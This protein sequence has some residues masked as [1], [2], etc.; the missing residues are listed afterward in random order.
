[1]TVAGR[2]VRGA[3]GRR[4]PVENPAC[5]EVFAH[6]PV[7]SAEQ[8]DDTVDAAA[9]AFRSW[10]ALP[11]RRRRALL[12]ACRTALAVRE[13]DLAELLTREQGKPLRHALAEV[14]AAADWFAH[15]AA[16]GLRRRRLVDDGRAE[17]SLEHVPYGV[18]AAIAP[19][20]FPLLLAVCKIA[21][22]LLAGNTVVLKPAPETPL[23]SLLMGELLSEVLPPGTLSV[24]SGDAAVGALLARHNAVRLISFT[25]SIRVGQDIARAAA[26]DLKRIVLELGGN[27]PAIVLPDADPERVAPELFRRAMVNSGQFCAAVKRVYVPRDKHDRLVGLLGSLARSTVV[28]DGMD[29]R[30]ALGPLVCAVQRDRVAGLVDRAVAAGARLAAGGYALPGPGY[31]YRPTVV[32]D[33]PPGTALEREEQFGPV[34]PVVPYDTVPEA[35]D[36][37]GAGAHALGCSLWG[38]ER[39]ARELASGV[40][41]GTVWVNTH[42][43]LRHDVPFGGHRASGVGVEYGYWGLLEYTQIRVHNIALGERARDNT[44]DDA[45]IDADNDADNDATTA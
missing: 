26:T 4:L 24:V 2:P 9:T 1:M 7:A 11:P 21:P 15:T 12:R 16:L 37:A 30:S 33:L 43:D 23:S 5:G 6:A 25:G 18:V 8:L 3:P 19:S 36:R 14:R 41:C 34:I 32:A 31:F 44:D 29:P 45:A 10:A 20:N 13:R 35:L 42:G 22:A 38:D 40:E 39:R 27:D 28:G 17:I